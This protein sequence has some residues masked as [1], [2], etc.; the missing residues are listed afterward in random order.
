MTL[1]VHIARLFEHMR[2]AD[3]RVVAALAAWPDAS[4]RAIELLAHVL[5][6]E[7]VWL[8]RLQQRPPDTPV[9]PSLDVD[10]CR[11]LLDHNREQYAAYLARL[12]PNDLAGTI[13][14]RNSAGVEFDS[15][16]EDILLHVAL[17]GSYHRGQ[18][19]LLVRDGGAEPN[20]TDYIAFVRGAAAAT[21]T[22]R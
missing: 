14:Y 2:W 11:A 19:A 13:R 20:A 4:P 15:Q 17:H 16:V 12:A 10:G 6:A 9:W 5:G 3:D 7:Q 18:I 22:I 1:P 8:A 21:R